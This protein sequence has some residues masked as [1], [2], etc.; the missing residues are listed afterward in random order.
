MSY[1][2]DGIHLYE[3]V[4]QQAY[5][6]WGCYERS[7]GRFGSFIRSTILRD[8]VSEECGVVDD[9]TLAALTEVS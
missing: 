2:T 4:S 8:C 6:N 7:G 5:R 9:L 1:L 3:V